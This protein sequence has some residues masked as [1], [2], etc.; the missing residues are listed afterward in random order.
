MA[1][2]TP[3]R[4]SHLVLVVEDDSEIRD[5]LVEILSD[6]GYVA[7]GASNGREA[8]Q[9]LHTLPQLPCFILLDLMMPIMDGITFREKQLADPALAHIPVVVI[10]ASRDLD[11]TARALGVIPMGKPLDLDRLLAL[12]Q[13]LCP[14][15]A[16]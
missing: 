1:A 6:T 10:S 16:A 9:V 11:A 7:H 3:P 2:A 13:R 12:A 4:P 8:L 15:A 14:G 5:S